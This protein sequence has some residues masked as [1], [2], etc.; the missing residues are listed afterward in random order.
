MFLN[1]RDAY[2]YR[3]LEALLLLKLQNIL[4]S[5]QTR[6]Q[7]FILVHNE[8]VIWRYFRKISIFLLVRSKILNF[9]YIN[10]ANFWLPWQ[11]FQQPGLAALRVENHFPRKPDSIGLF[12]WGS[13]SEMNPI[14]FHSRDESERRHRDFVGFV[15]QFKFVCESHHVQARIHG[16]NVDAQSLGDTRSVFN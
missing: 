1:R 5:S 7:L 16:G 9:L 2:G 13:S 11:Y 4:N 10:S 6:S 3:D 14:F 15:S 8:G 12:T